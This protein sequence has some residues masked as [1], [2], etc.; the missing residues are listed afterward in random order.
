MVP[1]T[2]FEVNYHG[3]M[4]GAGSPLAIYAMSYLP[5]YLRNHRH[6]RLVPCICATL[7][8]GIGLPALVH[9]VYEP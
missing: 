3:T 8:Y 7:R 1:S 6:C 5:A 9:R 2:V 4:S